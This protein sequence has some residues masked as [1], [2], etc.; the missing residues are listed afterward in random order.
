MRFKL[1]LIPARYPAII[2]INYQY[3]ISSWIYKVLAEADPKYATFLHREGYTTEKKRFK[4]FTFS[5]LSSTRYE[6]QKRDS[7]L[8]I[9]EGECSLLISF[10]INQAAENFV[11]GLFKDQKFGLGDR[12]S[13][14][15]FVVKEVAL[16][17]LLDFKEKMCYHILSPMIISANSTE[18]KYE[19]YLS[20]SDE[21]FEERFKKNLLDKYLSTG[22]AIDLAWQETPINLKILSKEPKAK[23][24]TIKA[25]TKEE[26]KVKGYMFDFELTA[27][28]QFQKIGFLAGFGRFCSQGF[29]AVGVVKK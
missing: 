7:R 27:P 8:K 26:S 29:G 6:I 5:Q 20:P 15:D 10:H 24:I 17:P 22:Q 25:H 16:V 1:T 18:N 21:R 12:I 13:Q 4:L 9:L 19:D 11:M 28:P 14:A 23:L 2:P 3:E